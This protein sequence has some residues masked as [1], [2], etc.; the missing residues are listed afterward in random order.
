MLSRKRMSMWMGRAMDRDGKASAATIFNEPV[1]RTC[2]A[3]RRGQLPVEH[4]F[5]LF[6]LSLSIVPNLRLRARTPN[7]AMSAQRAP[8]ATQLQFH[9]SISILMK[10]TGRFE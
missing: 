5:L 7:A 2:N 1:R 3:E 9:V 6:Y 4:T 10:G 8:S